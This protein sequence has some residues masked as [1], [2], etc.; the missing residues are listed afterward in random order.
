MVQIKNTFAALCVLSCALLGA[1]CRTDDDVPLPA[2]NDENCH[3]ARVAQMKNKKAQSEF[4]TK[5]ATRSTYEPSK[6]RTW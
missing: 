5:C 1:C 2:L 4:A 6:P 3:P